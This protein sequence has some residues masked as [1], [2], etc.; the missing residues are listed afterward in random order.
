MAAEAGRS[1]LVH[2]VGEDVLFEGYADDFEGA[3]RGV[4]FSLDGGL[5]WTTYETVGV[6]DDRGV[7]W[8][9]VYRPQQAGRYLL[10]A[11]AVAEGGVPSSVISSFAFE[12]LEPAASVYGG[13]GLRAVGGGSLRS[14]LA[15]RSRELVNVTAEEATFLVNALGVRSVYDIRNQREVAARPEP[16]LVGVKMVAVEPS[17]EKR[18]KN[19]KGRLRAGV[20]GEYGAPG[21]RMCDNYRRY[22]REYPLIGMVLRSMAAEGQPALVHCKNGKDR[23]GVLCAVLLRLAGATDEAIMA[24]YLRTNEVNA[25]QNEHDLEEMG[26]GMTA[27][28]RAILWSFLEA[29]PEYLRAFFDEID[30]R[31]GS[32]DRYVAQGLRLSAVERDRLRTM[33]G[34]H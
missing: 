21:E 27:D 25:A 16:C 26:V 9:F 23:T 8:S 4:Q 6:R 7:R 32:F 5:S 12:V 18:A 10:R 3:I 24:D 30:L 29:R 2:C 20:I 22:V 19:A 15:F 17:T 28:E 13:F 34:V 14:A 11:R 1:A 33:V 31:Y